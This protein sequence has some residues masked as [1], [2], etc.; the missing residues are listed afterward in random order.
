[1]ADNNNNNDDL[2]HRMEAWE[3]T[4]KAQQE[5]L[6][7]IQRMLAQLLINWTNEENTDSHHDDE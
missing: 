1:M 6:K 4:S 5:A 7:N 2:H 3:L